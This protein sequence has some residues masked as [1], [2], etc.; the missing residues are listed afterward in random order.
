MRRNRIHKAL[1]CLL[2]F[3]HG[4]V[5]LLQLVFK[6]APNLDVSRARLLKFIKLRGHF[7]RDHAH[8]PKG[9]CRAGDRLPVT[10]DGE[11]APDF[12]RKVLD[13][14]ARGRRR[15]TDKLQGFFK[16]KGV[17]RHHQQGAGSRRE[18]L[19]AEGRCFAQLLKHLHMVAGFVHRTDKGFELNRQ[20]LETERA[21]QDGIGRL[22]RTPKH[23]E[24]RLDVRQVA[25]DGSRKA[26]DLVQGRTDGGPGRVLR[27]DDVFDY[28]VHAF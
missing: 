9:H 26:L 13:G 6:D 24:A 5:V 8:I 4:P 7:R 19:K 11:G 17:V 2:G 20:R 22:R 23:L 12:M 10:D 16:S 1:S 15:I 18:R 3:G 14:R 25:P 28:L 21:L 27:A